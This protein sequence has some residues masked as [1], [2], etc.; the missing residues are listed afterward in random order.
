MGRYLVTGAAGFIGAHLARTLMEQG[1][2]CI[3]IDNLS[4]GFVE[5]IPDGCGFIQGNTYDPEVISSLKGPFD[6][7]FHIAGQSGGM[8]SFDDPTY[9]MNS[10][11]TA[12]LRLLDWAR[13]NGC[14]RF[15]YAS[16]MS[17]YGDEN[18]C[19]VTESGG[20]LQP[21]TFYAIGKIAS[22]QYMKI[23]T[24]FGLECVALRFNNTYGCGQNM[25]N[26]RQG[27]VSIFL[28]QAVK[29]HHIHVMGD[30]N[31][32]RDFVHVDDVVSACILAGTKPVTNA[33]A[34]YNVAT[35]RKT[36]CGEL[37]DMIRARLPYDVTV[38][39]EGSTPGDQFGIYCTYDKIRQE[40][41][42]EPKVTLERGLDEMV[43]WAQ[44][45][46]F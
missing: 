32:F 17:V 5:N 21:K 45:Q 22:E 43:D 3:T 27:M 38:Q 2:E 41:G 4:T 26:L 30:K 16:S 13:Q 15:V 14:R 36:T 18:L 12:T 1:N 37:V 34:A 19:P 44:K 39:Y 10:N 11:I 28:A 33:Y 35:N 23:Y 9:D 7:I 8:T 24:Q 40:F 46:E 6:A 29:N 20:K 31:R 42:W 25:K